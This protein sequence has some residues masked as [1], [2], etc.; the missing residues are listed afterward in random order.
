MS[1]PVR[2]SVKIIL[3]NE[4]DELL[5]MCADNP[6]VK[7]PDGKYHGRFWFLIGGEIEKGESIEEAAVRELYE[8]TGL[9]KEEVTLG[10]VVWYGEFD[11]QLKGSLTHLKQTFI[12]ARTKQRR[13]SFTQLDEW[14]KVSLVH[15]AW[16]SLEEIKNC[17]EVIYP[18]VLPEILPSIISGE[19]PKKPLEIDLARQPQKK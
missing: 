16:F 1:C 18:I 8:E 11:L 17:K 12:V 7:S 10:P 19:Y 4:K 2:N 13:V 9:K 15:L 5:L 3:L 14:E 6:Q